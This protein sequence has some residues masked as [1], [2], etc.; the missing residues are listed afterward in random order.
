MVYQEYRQKPNVVIAERQ[1][2]DVTLPIVI[3]VTPDG[4]VVQTFT[5][6][7]GDYIIETVMNGTTYHEWMTQSEFESQY[8][9]NV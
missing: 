5:V 7:A 4:P 1:P 3:G 2:Q 9:R 8:E 6:P